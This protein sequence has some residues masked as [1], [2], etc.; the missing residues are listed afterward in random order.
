MKAPRPH[1]TA[2]AALNNTQAT[3]ESDST[4][5]ADHRQGGRLQAAMHTGKTQ[6][7]GEAFHVTN[8]PGREWGAQTLPSLAPL[9]NPVVPIG[10][11]V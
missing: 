1:D 9:S 7:S 11:A 4:F 8:Q 2:P 3:Q 10:P 6:E 5:N